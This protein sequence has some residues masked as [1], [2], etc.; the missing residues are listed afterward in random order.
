M[1]L[2]LRQ[3]VSQFRRV[4]RRP[5]MP[6]DDLWDGPRDMNEVALEPQAIPS[7]SALDGFLNA[8]P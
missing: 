5:V 6:L 7:K 1:R 8:P 3:V 4:S 2:E